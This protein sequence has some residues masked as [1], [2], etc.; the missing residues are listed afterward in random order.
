[1]SKRKKWTLIGTAFV[2]MLSLTACGQN[3]SAYETLKQGS[4]KLAEAESFDYAGSIAFKTDALPSGTDAATAQA[5]LLS[6]LE[7]AFSGASYAKKEQA[8]LNLVLSLKGDAS[9]S[10]NVPI[11]V[12]KEGLYVKIP[13]IPMFPLP[14]TV[15]GKYLHLTKAELE[16]LS[17]ESAQPTPKP[18]PAK[19]K[20]LNKELEA[21]LAKQFKEDDNLIKVSVKKS[22]AEVPSHV[23][24]VVEYSITN[25]NFPT[26]VEKL[27][28]GLIPDILTILSKPEYKEM[29]NIPTDTLANYQKSLD[30]FTTEELKKQLT[31]NEAYSQFGI[32]GAGYLSYLRDKFDFTATDETSGKSNAS[33]D[34]TFDATN[35]N[36]A[37]GQVVIPKAEETISMTELQEQF[38]TSFSGL[39]ST[40]D[41]GT[42]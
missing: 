25:E 24:Q 19:E 42:P 38:G 10:V 11:V 15:T 16:Q 37:K 35:I 12:D 14:E 28:K 9:F 3:K 34:L 4:A 30:S 40:E 13:S 20:Q 18:D 22:S 2:L 21:A 17:D 36:K 7:L 26:L 5:Q 32:D 33:I 29:T 23:K 1:M 27:V 31:V 8:T 6:N 39:G 41:P